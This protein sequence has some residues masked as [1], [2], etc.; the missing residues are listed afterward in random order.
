MTSAVA[1]VMLS[2]KK[3]A[4][5]VWRSHLAADNIYIAPLQ[6]SKLNDVTTLFIFQGI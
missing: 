2:V 3:R 1:E 4:F 5:T 6:S